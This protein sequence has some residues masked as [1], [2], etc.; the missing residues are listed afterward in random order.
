MLLTFRHTPQK[1]LPKNISTSWNCRQHENIADSVV[2]SRSE[3]GVDVWKNVFIDTDIRTLW[4]K[5][6]FHKQRITN[7]K[8][9]CCVDWLNNVLKIPKKKFSRIA[10]GEG[11]PMWT[12]RTKLLIYSGEFGNRVKKWK[13]KL[14]GF[15][16]ALPT[17]LRR[18]RKINAIYLLIRKLDASTR[19]LMWKQTLTC[20]CAAYTTSFSSSVRLSKI[21]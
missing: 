2:F 20:D 18:I 6:L 14:F 13:V 4:V 8:V 1:K 21:E 9:L 3:F 15:P 5:M 19:S 12:K 16:L 10:T 17:Y 11:L 7:W